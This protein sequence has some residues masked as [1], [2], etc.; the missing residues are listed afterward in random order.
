MPASIVSD[1]EK[2]VLMLYAWNV[3]FLKSG[4][5]FS[6]IALRY[7]QLPTYTNHLSITK[8]RNIRI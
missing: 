1:A 7:M 2:C 3:A 8:V 6:L 4:L 5:S